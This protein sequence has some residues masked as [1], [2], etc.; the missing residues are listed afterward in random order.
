MIGLGH[1]CKML[2]C[3][4]TIAFGPTTQIYDV[5]TLGWRSAQQGRHGKF[6]YTDGITHPYA[7]MYQE[8]N[9]I[10]LNVLCDDACAWTGDMLQQ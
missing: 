3:M 7:F 4:H 9:D 6:L 2:V 10:L 1:N 8:M 5:H